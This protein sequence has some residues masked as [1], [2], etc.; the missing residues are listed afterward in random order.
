M[1]KFTVKQSE[2]KVTNQTR[3]IDLDVAT[4]ICVIKIQAAAAWLVA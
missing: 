1:L 2:Q 3:S 4:Y